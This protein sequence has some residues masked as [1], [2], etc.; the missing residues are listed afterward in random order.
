MPEPLYHKCNPLATTVVNGSIFLK[1]LTKMLEEDI[2]FAQAL[3]CSS[4]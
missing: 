1:T 3:Q 4:L 2:I